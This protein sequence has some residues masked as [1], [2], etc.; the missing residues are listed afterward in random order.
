MLEYVAETV[1]GRKGHEV[2]YEKNKKKVKLWQCE[3]E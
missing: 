2:E 3:E 1:K